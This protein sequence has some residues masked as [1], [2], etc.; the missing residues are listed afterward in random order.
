MIEYRFAQPGDMESIIDLINMVFSMLRVPHDFAQMLPKVYS[1]AHSQPQIH[2]V[3]VEDGRVLGCLALLEYPITVAGRTLRMGYLGSMAVHP[4]LRGQGVMKVLM[5]MQID[6][7]I[8]K[9][10]DMMVL[11]GQRQRYQ[12]YGFETCGAEYAYSISTP[13]V[14]H[15]LRD[16]DTQGLTFAPMTAADVPQAKALYDAQAVTGARTAENFLACVSSYREK[17]YVIAVNGEAAGYM[18]VT[19]DGAAVTEIL[20]KDDAL[21]LPALKG[22]MQ[23]KGL[24]GLRVEAAPHDVRL[25]GL[26]APICEGYT[27]GANNM[28][29]MLKPEAVIPAFMA[30]KKTYAPLADG[31]MTAALSNLGTYEI[32]VEHGEIR[33]ARTGREAQLALSQNDMHRL[34]FGFNPFAVPAAARHMAPEGWF[35]LPYCIPMPDSF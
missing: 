30:L 4:K 21:I 16:E 27:I 32:A 18:V 33:V 14:R 31:C 29:R 22:F 23:E 3:A 8:A 15:A 25:N 35:P 6:A 9:G 24:R 2:A 28:M 26:L 1:E 7:G 17:P 34:L 20:T 10:L 19:E 5:Q 12:Y 11:G 13:N